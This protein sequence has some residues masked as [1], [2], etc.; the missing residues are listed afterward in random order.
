V[1][2]ALV[3]SCLGTS[4]CIERPHQAGNRHLHQ[5][6]LV[7]WAWCSCLC[8]GATQ[9][10][11]GGRAGGGG[12][13]SGVP[14]CRGCILARPAGWCSSVLCV[15]PSWPCVCP[16]VP[17][18]PPWGS[19]AQQGEGH[20]LLCVKYYIIQTLPSVADPPFL[21]PA[22]SPPPLTLPHPLPQASPWRSGP[23]APWRPAA[24]RRWC[25]RRR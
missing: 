19:P 23:L 11:A 7:W 4:R 9:Q 5:R 10:R 21:P 22:S 1:A 20:L 24:P 8:S 12:C 2:K 18:A 17:P 13:R 3:S 6:S 15:P 25:W 14:Q 16:P